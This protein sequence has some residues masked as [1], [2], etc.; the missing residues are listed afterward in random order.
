[1][2]R[3]AHLSDVHLGPLPDVAYRD[4]VS[5][6]ITGYVNWHRNRRQF[7]H[8]SVIDAIVGDIK[9]SGANHIAVT[10]D[11]VN[12]ALDIEIDMAKQWLELLGNPH[13]VSVVPG[14]HDAYVPGAFDKV[15]RAWGNWMTGDGANPP[16]DR[17]AFPY[18]RLRGNVALIGVTSARA[19][20]PFMATGYF[21]EG[22]S[23]RMARLLDAT[24]AK[25]LF[26]VV[27]IHHPPIRNAVGPHKRLFGIGRFQKTVLRHGAELVVH[28]HSH[29]PSL[30]TIAGKDG[31][32]PVVGVAAAGQAPGGSKPAAQWNQLDISGDRDNWTLRLTRRGLTGA[33]MPPVELSSQDLLGETPPAVSAP[34]AVKG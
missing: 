14:N 25:G 20:A 27:M 13:D 18:L 21:R 16:R 10:G 30:Y 12:L 26:R 17:D 3:L 15:C 23:R 7:L 29:L 19:T 2:F 1:M 31:T 8:D 28:G 32:V 4:L 11:L 5:K 6:R 22:Q 24:G 34:L 9:A 33:S